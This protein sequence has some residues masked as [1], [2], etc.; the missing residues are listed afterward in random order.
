MPSS[1]VRV[2]VRSVLAIAVLLWSIPAHAASGDFDL[3][4]FFRHAT[5]GEG[6]IST[7][8]G[9]QRFAVRTGGRGGNGQLRMA[10]RFRYADG[11]ARLQDWTIRKVGRDYVATRPDLKG[12][13]RFRRVSP[14]SY[15]YTWRQW[16]DW[17]KRENLVTVRGRLTREGNV[18]VNR[19][20][21][22]KG[23]IPVAS[24]RVTFRE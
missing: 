1:P 10:E 17:P 9:T 21:A 18:V 3:A 16:Y 13:A 24:I 22:F 7:L 6:R 14:N 20:T 15:A 5:H 11:R 8:L 23:P 12:P 2:P 4:S 19:A